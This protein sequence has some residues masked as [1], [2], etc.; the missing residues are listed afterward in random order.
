M[1]KP[2]ETTA[3]I[4]YGGINVIRTRTL[5]N[6]VF[7]TKRL[8]LRNKKELLTKIQNEFVP[9]ISSSFAVGMLFDG[10]KKNKIVFAN[11]HIINSLPDSEYCRSL[12][13]KKSV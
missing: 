6:K 8:V 3:A 2:F 4:F 9:L 13:K 7:P 11:D 5:F 10:K 12:L 1:V